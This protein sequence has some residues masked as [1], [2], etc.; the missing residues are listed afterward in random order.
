MGESS[1]DGWSPA[2]DTR[3][4]ASESRRDPMPMLLTIAEVAELLR[5]S[6]KA[7]Y[8]MVDRRQLPGVT[9]VGRRVLVRSDVLLNWLHQKRTPSL[10]G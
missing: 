10:E 7:V 3:R 9:R 2:V 4:G 6:A 8:S 1:S 5:T